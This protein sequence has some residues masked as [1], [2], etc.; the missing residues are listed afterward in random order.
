MTVSHSLTP[1]DHESGDGS[2]S[3][4]FPRWLAGELSSAEF[5]ELEERLIAD[6]AFRR[7]Y[8]EYMDLEAC[9]AEEL[10]VRPEPKSLVAKRASS[11]AKWGVL[12]T[13]AACVAVVVM[14]WPEGNRGPQ[15]ARM[16]PAV[17]KAPFDDDKDVVKPRIRHTTV[18]LQGLPDIAVVTAY[19]DPGDRPLAVGTRLKPGV[20]TVDE[21]DLQLDF[22]GGARLLV[23]GP[24]E[25]HVVSPTAATLVQG[26]VGVRMPYSLESF[27]LSTPDSAVVGSWHE[28]GVRVLPDRRTRVQVH[29]GTAELSLLGDDGTTLISERLRDREVIEVDTVERQFLPLGETDDD[30][31]RVVELDQAQL[32]VS[33]DYVREIEQSKPYLYWRFEASEDGRIPDSLGGPHAARIVGDADSRHSIRIVNGAAEFLPSRSTR[34]IVSEHPIP[35]FNADDFTIEL[36]VLPTEMKAAAIFSTVLPN[37]SPPL[38]LNF[39]EIAH[40]THLVH[41]PGVLRFLHRQPAAQAGGYNL[42]SQDVCTPGVWTH[43]VATKTADELRLYINGQLIRSVTGPGT[44]SSDD[45]S[46]RLVLGQLGTNNLERQYHGLIDEVAVYH[47]ALR[48]EEISRHYWSIRRGTPLAVG[49]HFGDN[50]T[51][52]LRDRR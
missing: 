31:P 10:A 26:V 5:A 16:E 42:F 48:S 25:L 15:P 41:K 52:A 23:R 1:N 14:L 50:R 47:R 37:E 7:R 43:L 51:V 12:A 9:L 27:A 19:G 33:A 17:A 45:L 34:C 39:I 20:L 2:E 6:P 30:W 8:L 3:V 44:G 11:P 38:H 4:L 22:L 35:R 24:A 40:N 28:Y 32:V 29:S 21:G 46:Y 18:P 49:R 36:W 13:V